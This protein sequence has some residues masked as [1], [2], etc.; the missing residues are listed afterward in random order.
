MLCVASL[1]KL[2]NFRR[3]SSPTTTTSNSILF[4]RSKLHGLNL[5]FLPAPHLKHSYRQPRIGKGTKP[6]K[7]AHL[8]LLPIPTTCPLALIS[9]V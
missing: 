9:C 5:F 8:L 2:Q 3:L 6:I 1:L 4:S 7:Q